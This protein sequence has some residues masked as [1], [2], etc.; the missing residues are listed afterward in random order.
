M[1]GREL[2]EAADRYAERQHRGQVDKADRPYIEHPRRV[3]AR[4]ETPE[5]QAVALLHDVLEDTDTT[6]DDLR[7]VGFPESVIDA[8][9]VLTKTSDEPYLA[10]IRRAAVHP[11]AGRVK[12][13]DLSD[14]SDPARLALLDHATAGRLR[15][16]YT[17]AMAVLRAAAASE[18]NHDGSDGAT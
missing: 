8:I 3:A 6:V 1:K 16:K 2:V 17:E 13:A 9:V 7:S 15:D 12:L 5:E 10:A 4:L 14:N 18:P 11:V